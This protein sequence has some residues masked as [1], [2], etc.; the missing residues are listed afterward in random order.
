MM[1]QMMG[2]SGNNAGQ[3][4]GGVS[5]PPETQ[6][7]AASRRYRVQLEMLERMGFPD[8]QENIQGQPTI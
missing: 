6:E 5:S 3:S 4:T 8:R 2:Q 1:G 7:Q